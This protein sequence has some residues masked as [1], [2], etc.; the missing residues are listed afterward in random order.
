MKIAIIKSGGKQYKVQ[1]GTVLKVEKLAGEK[2]SDIIFDK[3]LLISDEAGND[4]QLG[5]PYL[6]N[7][8]VKAKILEQ[9]RAKKV[10]GIKYKPKV[11]HRIKFGHRQMFTKVQIL[12]V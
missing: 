12:A 3:V 1:T 7:A 4:L 10:T 11:R 6:A 5:N 9:G 2:N 8:Q